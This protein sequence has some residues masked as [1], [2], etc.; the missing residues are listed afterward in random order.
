MTAGVTTVSSGAPTAVV[1]SA[2]SSLRT[3]V[4]TPAGCRALTKSSCCWRCQSDAAGRGEV[5]R[6]AFAARGIDWRLQQHLEFVSALQSAGVPTTV[7]D[8]RELEHA[9]LT[10]A[11]GAPGDTV[12]TPALMNFLHGCFA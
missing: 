7:L 12:V 10:T 8:S 9:D 6:D 5:S 3:V 4:G 1:R 2:C 11:V